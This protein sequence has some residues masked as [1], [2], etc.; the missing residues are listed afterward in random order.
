MKIDFYMIKSKSMLDDKVYVGQTSNINSRMSH[1]K[2][3]S[4]KMLCNPLYDYIR[5]NGGWDNMDYTILESR[6]IN[7]NDTDKNKKIAEIERYYIK[8]FKSRLNSQMPLRTPAE[9]RLENKEKATK[10][11]QTPKLCLTCG[12]YISSRNHARHNRNVHGHS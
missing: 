5:D 3:L 8:L 7:K 6:D 2:C 1:H 9:Y 4:N 10:Y 11:L 12:K